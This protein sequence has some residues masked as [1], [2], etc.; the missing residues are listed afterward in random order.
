MK[1]I[2][3]ILLISFCL[4]LAGCAWYYWYLDYSYSGTPETAISKYILKYN[5]PFF[6]P[7]EYQVTPTDTEDKKYGRLFI[8]EGYRDHETGKQVRFF[9][10]K[11]DREKGWY[12]TSAGT[13]P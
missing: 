13:G 7:T 1:V 5:N 9:Y 2:R 10:L 12:V 6:W 4:V 11:R 3:S 8:V